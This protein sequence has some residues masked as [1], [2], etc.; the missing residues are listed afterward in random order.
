MVDS[1]LQAV[2][3]VVGFKLCNSDISALAF[4]DD[5]VLVAS[6]RWGLQETIT[7]VEVAA[8]NTGLVLNIA[9]SSTLSI[10]PAGKVKKSKVVTKHRFKT[11][12]GLLPPTGVVGRWVYLGVVF[13]AA[14]RYGELGLPALTTFISSLV[15]CRIQKLKNSTS[16]AAREAF[17]SHTIQRKLRWGRGTLASSEL[18]QSAP[19]TTDRQAVWASLLHNSVNGMCD[20]NV[21]LTPHQHCMRLLTMRI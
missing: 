20:Y 18:P 9:K 11:T 15:C 4:A 1:I 14:I 21:L 2:S 13:G 19:T 16:E 5:L 12:L 3:Q 10:V 8:S 7:K 6:S 17:E